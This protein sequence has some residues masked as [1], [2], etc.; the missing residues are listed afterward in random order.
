MIYN[1]KCIAGLS[2]LSMLICFGCSDKGTQ[3]RTKEAEAQH[4]VSIAGQKNARIKSLTEEFRDKPA[5]MH[6]L[7]AVVD[8]NFKPRIVGGFPAAQGLLPWQVALLLRPF[9]NFQFCGGSVVA[10]GW[11][12][13]AAHCVQSTATSKPQNL[14]VYANSTD[15]DSGGVQANVVRI[16]KHP[17]WDSTTNDN[18]IALLGVDSPL[19][20]SN[21]ISLIDPAEED[22]LT[23]ATQE[24]VVSGWGAIA[25]SG[26][27]SRKLLYVDLPFV[28]RDSCNAPD[29]Y[30]GAIT[31][32]MLCAG[33]EAK[34]SCQGDSGGPLVVPFGPSGLGKPAK[35]VGIVSFGEGCARE[36]KYGVYTR[37]RNYVDWIRANAK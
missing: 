29:S 24:G 31:E 11:I 20:V 6:Q 23:A 15:L 1:T 19:N 26:S 16:V 37:V 34:D 36:K 4:L 9:N 17:K 18:D 2:I 27:S 33:A 7:A 25:E 5:D 14:I 22:S 8:R 30:N 12:L 13:T 21:V 35:L 10:P 28:T 32:N 3:E